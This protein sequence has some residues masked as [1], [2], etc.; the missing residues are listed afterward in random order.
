MALKKEIKEK[1]YKVSGM[2]CSSCELIIEKKLINLPGIQSVDASTAKNEVLME[3][4]GNEP[5]AEELSQ[6]F[7]QEKYQFSD[8]SIK[9]DIQ[10]EEDSEKIDNN[11]LIV[12][13]ILLV[14]SFL[15][16]LNGLGITNFV[17]V[18]ANSSLLAFLA[19]GVVAGLSSCAALVGGLILSMSKQWLDLYSYEDKFSKKRKV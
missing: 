17:N 5:R 19:L 3:Y 2:H 1:I 11:T 6:L 18:N 9:A 13:S 10:K 15:F 16:I 4:E 14:I 8:R 7:T 12:V